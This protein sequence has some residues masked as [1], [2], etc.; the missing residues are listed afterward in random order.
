MERA[1]VTGGAGFI[2]SHLV[3]RLVDSG[4][5]VLVIDDLSTGRLQRLA[6][7]RSRGKVGFHQLDLRAPELIEV[8]CRF[9]PQTIFHLAAHADVRKST[10]DPMHDASVNV[11]GT[12]NVLMAAR[13]A[14]AERVV[15]TSTGGALYGETD[16]LPTRE[17]VTKRPESPYGISKKVVEDYFRYFRTAY[18][19]DYAILA[20][21][22]V[23]GP[24]QDPYGEAGV[25]AIFARAMLDRRRPVIFGD[26]TQT[27][28]YVYV[29]DVVDGLVRSAARG[30]GGLYNI[31]TG[32]ETSVTDLYAAL[33][34]ITGFDQPPEYVEAKPGDLARSCLDASAAARHLGWEPFTSLDEGLA[35]TAGWF[36]AN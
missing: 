20:L 36:R 30:G 6:D 32:R 21:A 10:A 18:G 31:G 4:C 5:E 7:A 24:R 17:R 11:L 35:L 29:V 25:V 27:R 3:D 14:A 15:F 2:G 9:R 8:A 34:V 33:A 13:D 23:Y 22:N 28:D 26:G 16:K 19:L 12:L 1:I